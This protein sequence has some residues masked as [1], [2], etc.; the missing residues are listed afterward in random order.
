MYRTVESLH[1]IPESIIT[2]LIIFEFL[3]NQM[4]TG[5]TKL[6]MHGLKGR[7]MWIGTEMQSLE[8]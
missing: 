7:E 1:C 3:K 5:A 8:V 6:K 4:E 2:V